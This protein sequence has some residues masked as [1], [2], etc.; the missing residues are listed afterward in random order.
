MILPDLDS[1]LSPRS[2]AIVGASTNASKIGAVPVRYLIEHGYDGAIFP[3]NAHAQEIEGRR[4]YRSL[5]A[6]NAP[7]DLAIFAIPASS[8]SAALDDAIVAK[9]R[10]IVMF[11]AGF[12]EMGDV[13]KHAQAAL[14]VKAKAAGI[15]VLGPNCLGFMNVA[16][17]VYATF[18]PVVA[19][20]KNTPGNVGIVSQSGAF[21]AYAYAMARERGLG[22]SA[23]V[24]TGNESD[25]DVADC[26]AWMARDSATQVIM[27]YLE[28]CHDGGKLRHALDLAS[29]AGKPVVIVKVGRTELGALTAASHTAALAG[30]DAVFNAMFKQHGAYR[31]T[32]IEAFFDIGH[33]LAVAGLPPNTQVGLLTVSG[34]VGVMMADE[35]QEAGLEVA[36]MPPAAQALIRARVPLAATHNPVDITGQVTAEPEVL[37]VAARAMLNEADY[38]SVLIF[39]AAFGATPAMQVLQQQL[40][41]ALRQDFPERLIIFSTLTDAVQQRALEAAGCLSFTDPARAVQVMAAM[42]FFI[43]HRERRRR[44]VAAMPA[45]ESANHGLPGTHPASPHCGLAAQR[46]LRRA[47]YNEAD[48]LEALAAYGIPTVPIRR[49]TTADE[50]RRGAQSLGFPVAMKILSADIQHKS[51]IGGVMLNVGDPDQV[52]AAFA[53]IVDA[54]RSHLP[55][56][57]VD[58]VLIAPMMAAGVECILGARR[59]PALGVVIMLGSGGVNVELLGDV[60]FRLAPVDV[61][62]AREMIDELKTARLFHGFRG[63]APSD[64]DALADAIVQLSRFALD[65]GDALDS[66]EIN[67]FMVRPV[68]QGALALDAVLLTAPPLPAPI[69]ASAH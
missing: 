38:G 1:F 19:T 67:P 20:G 61:D 31:A 17:G 55:Q 21:G 18:S 32:T 54:A 60:T 36:A 56:A 53:R 50:A 30:D 25:I 58:G 62:Q 57:H 52:G 12:A 39:L 47:G 29:T 34:G 48:A 59:D 11:S 28:G 68:G 66:V 6:V 43:L 41:Q 63:A 26:I 2:I 27:A 46:S 22:L 7:I 24:T 4:A 15:R 49:A 8:V 37:E 33:G 14:T 9:V 45:L 69:A 64:V 3:I 40:A 42:R 35:A 16:K 44:L 23:W 51:D 5:Q 65:A 10:N 13:G